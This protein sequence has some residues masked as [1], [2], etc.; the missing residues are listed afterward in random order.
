MPIGTHV[1]GAET[2]KGRPTPHSRGTPG[3]P[4]RVPGIRYVT[5]RII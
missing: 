3:Q 2:A 5:E 4:N 1:M